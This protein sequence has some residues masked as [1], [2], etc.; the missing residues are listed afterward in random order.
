[1]LERSFHALNT[2]RRYPPPVRD[3][4]PAHARTID[5]SD[6][7]DGLVRSNTEVFGDSQNPLE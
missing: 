2:R 6:N 7:P 5:F 1:M 4:P 3:L